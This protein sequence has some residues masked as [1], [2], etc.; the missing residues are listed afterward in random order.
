MVR[1][2]A[3]ERGS[4][5]KEEELA[6]T[7]FEVGMRKGVVED[8]APYKACSECRACLSNH[9]WERLITRCVEVFPGGGLLMGFWRNLLCFG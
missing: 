5:A 1:R 9:S 8:G 3:R 4:I 7:Q 2:L 6:G